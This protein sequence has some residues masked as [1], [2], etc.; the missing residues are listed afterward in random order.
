MSRQHVSSGVARVLANVADALDADRPDGEMTETARTNLIAQHAPGQSDL[1][2]QVHAATPAITE[3]CS[4]AE[5]AT[6]LRTA[7]Q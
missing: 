1:F 2:N 4:R 5:Y 7:T 6:A 3:L